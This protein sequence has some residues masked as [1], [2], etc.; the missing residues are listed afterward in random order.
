MIFCK[1]VRMNIFQLPAIFKWKLGITKSCRHAGSREQA[2]GRQLFVMSAYIFS[3]HHHESEC[4][5]IHTPR[6]SISDLQTSEGAIIIFI[7]IFHIKIK[8]W[9]DSIIRSCNV[10]HLIQATANF[11]LI[12][13]FA[14]KNAANASR[15]KKLFVIWVSRDNSISSFALPA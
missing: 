6:F 8:S 9:H 4:Q 15:I 11:S 7:F 5:R 2:A 1:N 14:G 12:Q 10:T 3:Q 13:R